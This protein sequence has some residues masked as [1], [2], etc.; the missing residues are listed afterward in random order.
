MRARIPL[1]PL[2]LCLAV[3][4]SAQMLVNGCGKK[5]WPEPV[6]SEDR[7]FLDRPRAALAGGCLTVEADIVGAA[8]NLSEVVLEI[9]PADCP[10]C[11]LRPVHVVR[12]TERTGFMADDDTLKVRACNLEP[13]PHRWRLRGMNALSRMSARTTEVQLTEPAATDTP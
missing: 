4:L 3:L 9:G 2:L 1:P 7:F 13:G 10:D 12:F 6:R 11:P 8:A 5:S